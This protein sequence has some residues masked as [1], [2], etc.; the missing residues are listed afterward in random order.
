MAKSSLGF[1]PM[2]QDTTTMRM[3]A[4]PVERQ[5]QQLGA[6]EVGDAV[7]LESVEL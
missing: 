5:F 3:R 6:G 4:C 7:R 1:V 2:I